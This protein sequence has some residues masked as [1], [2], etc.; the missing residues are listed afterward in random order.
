MLFYKW[1]KFILKVFRKDL[2][3]HWENKIVFPNNLT[4]SYLSLKVN[5]LEP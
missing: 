2:L 3:L 1:R 4:S 5:K